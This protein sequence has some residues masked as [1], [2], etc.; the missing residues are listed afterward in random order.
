MTL[1]RATVGDGVNIVFMG[2]GYTMEISLQEHTT[3]Q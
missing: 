3:M 1:Q 2:D